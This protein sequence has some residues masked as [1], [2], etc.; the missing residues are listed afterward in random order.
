MN[1]NS[2]IPVTPTGIA[3]KSVNYQSCQ[4]PKIPDEIVLSK[5]KVLPNIRKSNADY[6]T[7]DDEE[8]DECRPGGALVMNPNGL[9]NRTQIAVQTRQFSK[10]QHSKADTLFH[11]GPKTTP[12]YDYAIQDTMDLDEDLPLPPGKKANQTNIR[13]SYTTPPERTLL[14]SPLNRPPAPSPSKSILKRYSP[15]HSDTDENSLS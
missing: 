6:N 8:D 15:H 14:T 3:F 5:Y 9:C 2:S 1:A 4:I 12:T 7:T 10:R 13:T 11:F